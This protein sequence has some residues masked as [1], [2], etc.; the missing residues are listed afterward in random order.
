MLTLFFITFIIAIAAFTYSVILTEDGHILHRLES[1]L[2]H[3]LPEWLYKPLIGCQYCVAGQWALWYYLMLFW[4]DL[5][6]YRLDVHIFFVLVTI[7]WVRP[8]SY[9]YEKMKE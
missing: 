3:K 9:L 8:V 4:A 5:T 1:N 7:Y 6:P 2:Y